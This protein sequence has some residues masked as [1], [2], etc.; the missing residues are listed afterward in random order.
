M[1]ALLIKRW[2]MSR[3][4]Y[5]FMLGF[6]ILPLIVEII[7]VAALPTPNEIQSS[8]IQNGR[9]KDAQ[10][11]LIPSM[12]NPQ[13]VV[14]YSNNDQN[15]ARTRF[16]NYLQGA[17]VTIEEISTDTVLSYVR[18]RYLTNADTFINK[19]QMSFGIY[20]NSTGSNHVQIVNSLFSTVNYHA[21]A[22][23]LSVGST[24]LFQF[25]ANSSAKRIITTNQ[26]ILTTN[27][28]FSANVLFF[29][30]IYCFDTLPLSLF[31]FL[32]SIVVAIFM[33][34]L[35]LPIIQERAS[36]SKDLQLLTNLSKRTYW[37][38][39]VTFDFSACLI[40][41]SL[42]TIVV[43]VSRAFNPCSDYFIQVFSRSLKNRSVQQLIQKWHQK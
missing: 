34:I 19:Y 6:F 25:Y 4:Q 33:S 13:T 42:L 1:L 26:P 12:Y 23:S 7:I 2:N 38:S 10:V 8:L 39:N 11:S 30:L 27:P 14:V 35:L 15:N 32:N 22:T 24:S 29:E 21:M 31:S 17:E 3:R 20:T 40:I 16:L 41:C 18:E 5:V 43:K 9:V 36:R 37:L 28:G